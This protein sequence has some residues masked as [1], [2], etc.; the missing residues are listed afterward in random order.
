MVVEELVPIS[1]D[2]VEGD[3]DALLEA[4]EGLGLVLETGVDLLEQ[5]QHVLRQELLHGGALL[6][7]LVPGGL[8]VGGDPLLLGV[9]LVSRQV[10]ELAHSL[11]H[12][13]LA[14]PLYCSY[15]NTTL[16]I[17]AKEVC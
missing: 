15:T 6:V 4:V 9:Q 17:L 3:R 1:D 14:L 16:H 11:Q 5:S 2:V 8:E 7:R 12:T 13:E 10:G